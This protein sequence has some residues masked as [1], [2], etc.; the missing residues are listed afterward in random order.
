MSDPSRQ[1]HSGPPQQDD[2]NFERD[3]QEML[4]DGPSINEITSN[5]QGGTP[6]SVSAK[7][8][9]QVGPFSAGSSPGG[10]SSAGSGGGAGG[11]AGAGGIL[12]N[13]SGT[14]LTRSYT[15][16]PGVWHYLLI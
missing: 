14:R 12:Y 16:P 2:D 13:S 4:E 15:L 9:E 6:N 11:A 3:L 1:P 5:V 7:F 8:A 10:A